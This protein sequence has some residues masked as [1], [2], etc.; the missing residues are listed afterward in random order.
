V[1]PRK[2]EKAV[3]FI[4]SEKKLGWMVRLIGIWL[5]QATTAGIIWLSKTPLP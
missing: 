2:P 3:T 4:A 1:R 5:A